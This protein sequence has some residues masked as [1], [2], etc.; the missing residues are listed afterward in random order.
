MEENFGNAV[1]VREVSELCQ[2]IRRY[3]E[4]NA[5]RLI[6]SRVL[7]DH[8]SEKIQEERHKRILEICSKY[9]ISI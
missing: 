7:I 2:L 9:S 6:E 1:D 8:E 4:F 3:D 5:I